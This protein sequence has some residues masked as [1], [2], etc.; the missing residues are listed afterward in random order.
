MGFEFEQGLDNVVN[1]KVIGIGGG[2]GNAVNRMISSGVQGVEFISV[3]TDMQ[4]LNYSQADTKIQIGEKLTKGQGAGAN[5]EIG[6]KAAEESKDQITAALA[7]TNMVFITAGMGGGTGT[8][9]APVVAQIAREMGILTVGVVTRPFGFEGKKRLEQALGGID[10]LGKN[11]DSLVIIPNERL[12]FVSEQKITFKNA[13]EIA[14]GVLRQAVAN[15]SELITVPGFINLDFADVTSVMKDAGFAHIGTGRAAG[16]DKAAEAARMAI[17]SPLLE[18]SI[19]M[20]R[21]VIVSVIGSDDIGLDEVETAAT[22]VQQAAHPDAHIIFGAFIDD[23]MDDE[24]RVVVIATG[25]DKAPNS[26]RMSGEG[27][28]DEPAQAAGLFTEATATA[29]EDKPSPSNEVGSDDA[30]FDVLMRIF[31]KDR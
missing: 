4:A 9:A 15:I 16:K 11:V 2:G 31:D 30:A 7:G 28:K 6:R 3:N 20:A 27:K 10:E 12:K 23:E 17:S 13:F 8:G 25:F 1:I 21:G 5:P 14:D 18:T 29:A 24:I 22:M 26:A 19:D